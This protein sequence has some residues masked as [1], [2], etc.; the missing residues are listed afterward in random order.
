MYIE[1][2]IQDAK[3]RASY[4]SDFTAFE[5]FDKTGAMTKGYALA[6]GDTLKLKIDGGAEKTVTFK[7]ADFG[8]ITK[9]KSDEV[10][11]VI[12]TTIGGLARSLEYKRTLADDGV[13]FHARQL[14][15]RADK[16]VEVTGGTALAALGFAK[17]LVTQN[18]TRFIPDI[19]DGTTGRA[20]E[21]AKLLE[22][23]M[24]FRGQSDVHGSDAIDPPNA[25]DT[26]S[27]FGVASEDKNGTFG[28]TDRAPH[29]L[30]NVGLHE[31]RGLIRN[32]TVCHEPGHSW[33]QPG[34]NIK[35]V[36]GNDF[37]GTHTKSAVTDGRVAYADSVVTG[38]TNEPCQWSDKQGNDSGAICPWHVRQMRD[39][40]FRT[41]TGKDKRDKRD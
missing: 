19:A 35:A 8:D 13:D 1:L 28:A 40:M 23:E 39:S 20:G 2:D 5:E 41:W 37:H 12:N 6:D 29:S 31:S 26:V 33:A 16:S 32:D 15:L 14:T 21:L 25:A 11:A 7:K 27:I 30:I 3:A 18:H 24:Y 10:V 34:Q 38:K 4:A 17:E 36:A 9:A 22:Y